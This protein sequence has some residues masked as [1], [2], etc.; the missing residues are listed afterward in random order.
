MSQYLFG[1]RNKIHIINL[2]HTLPALNEAASYLSTQA[3]RRKTILFVGTKRSAGKVIRDEARRCGMPFVDKRWLGGML[4]NY[5]TIRQSIRTLKDLEKQSTDGTFDLLTK[6]EAL[7]R[8]RALEKLERS[9]GGIK[10]MS[11]LPDV[12]FI[13]DVDHESIAV[14]EANKLGIPVVGI[15]DSNSSPVGID[16]VIPGNDDAIRSIQLLVGVVADAVIAGRRAADGPTSKDDFVEV[17]EEDVALG[18]RADDRSHGGAA[19]GQ[20]D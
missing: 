3:S 10:D 15:V 14:S 13:V 5:K 17:N 7:T 12:L 9:M 18:S 4:T 1:S 8:S 11:G 2:E 20:L 16:H 6:K 19:S